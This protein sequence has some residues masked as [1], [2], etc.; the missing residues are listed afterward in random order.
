MARVPHLAETAEEAVPDYRRRSRR[1]LM[2]WLA[3]SLVLHGALLVAL[4]GFVQNREPPKVQVLDVVLLRESGR[5]APAETR[6]EVLP[7]PPRKRPRDIP[8]STKNSEQRAVEPVRKPESEP[9]KPATIAV[10]EPMRAPDSFPLPAL[11][12][13]QGEA[14]PST[15]R[16]T[17]VAVAG[18]DI[19]AA[20]P[21]DF[22]AAYLR[23]PP[24]P[25]PLVARRNGE[26]GTVTLKV[27]VTREGI[28]ASVAVEKTSGSSHLDNAALET[29]RTW[30]FVP[31]RQGT[32]PVEA[33][34]LVPIVFRLEGT[35]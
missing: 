20:S 19:A 1:M 16:R 33:W 26:Q 12:A 27:L 25:Y 13:K 8:A 30:R 23:N 22:N 10:T 17:E 14:R 3:L 21:P 28:P 29:V 4:S 11:S 6:A 2:V 15:P 18:R 7:E 9:I 32:Q 34:V 5:P 31:A 35:S 24:P